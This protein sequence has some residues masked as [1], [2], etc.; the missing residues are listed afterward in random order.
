MSHTEKIFLRTFPSGTG[1]A[2]CA[3]SG[4]VGAVGA[5]AILAKERE[6]WKNCNISEEF[7]S[8]NLKERLYPEIK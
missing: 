7:R 2:G 3:D 8:A 4:G 1:Y 5:V 6:S